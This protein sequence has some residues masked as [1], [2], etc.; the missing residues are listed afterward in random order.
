MGEE[1]C[2]VVWDDEPE[3]ELELELELEDELLL[4]AVYVGA[5]DDADDAAGALLALEE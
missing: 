4:G 1:W 2:E 5:E 3:L